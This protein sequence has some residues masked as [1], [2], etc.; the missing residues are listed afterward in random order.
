[1]DK[2]ASR[3]D[4][5]RTESRR[6]WSPFNEKVGKGDESSGFARLE[7]RIQKIEEVLEYHFKGLSSL[8]NRSLKK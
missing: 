3:E 6:E 2:G 5:K 7:A 8:G 4:V 1:M